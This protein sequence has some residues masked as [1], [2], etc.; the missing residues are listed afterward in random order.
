M[1]SDAKSFRTLKISVF[2]FMR[3]KSSSPSSVPLFKIIIIQMVLYFVIW[4]S[5]W[6][7]FKICRRCCWEPFIKSTFLDE[8]VA[9]IYRCVFSSNTQHSKLQSRVRDKRLQSTQINCLE[10]FRP[11]RHLRE[12]NRV[13]NVTGIGLWLWFGAQLFG[14]ETLTRTPRRITQ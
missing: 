10:I 6:A 5:T 11:F 4:V 13:K 3:T 8:K 9:I 2:N 1:N 12:I 14:Q 7:D